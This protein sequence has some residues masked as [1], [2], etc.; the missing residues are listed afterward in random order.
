MGKFK[1][2]FKAYWRIF[3]YFFGIMLLVWIAFLLKI[4]RRIIAFGVIIIGFIT[5][6]FTELL[7]IIA[8][9]PVLGP[10]LVRIVSLP[11]IIIINALGYIVTF[12]AFRKGYK[13]EVA[14]SKMFTTA[15]LIGVVL[16]FILGKLL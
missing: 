15:M 12:F 9:I 8:L 6:L 3:L 1:S 5:Q 16:G 13:V 7:S 14:K 4:D 10:V 11:F 2:F